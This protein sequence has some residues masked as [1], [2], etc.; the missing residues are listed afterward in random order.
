MDLLRDR[1]SFKLSYLRRDSP[2]V[3]LGGSHTIPDELNYSKVRP[4]IDE[5]RNNATTADHDTA[6]RVTKHD[7][8][9]LAVS[10]VE[11]AVQASASQPSASVPTQSLSVCEYNPKINSPAAVKECMQPHGDSTSREIT[12]N[13]ESTQS[14]NVAEMKAAFRAMMQPEQ[15]TQGDTQTQQPCFAPRLP[16]ETTASPSLAIRSPADYASEDTRTDAKLVLSQTATARLEDAK[17]KKR[18]RARTKS[19]RSRAGDEHVTV[20]EC[21]HDEE[22]GEMVGKDQVSTASSH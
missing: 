12:P 17:A 2:R 8:H 10:L 19:K 16:S 18:T 13:D 15:V 7:S 11:I 4:L 3:G 9:S 1:T 5:A 14:S 21:G 6:S 20:C 22:E